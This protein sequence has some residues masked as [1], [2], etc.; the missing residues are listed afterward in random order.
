MDATLFLAPSV[1]SL[2]KFSR[3]SAVQQRLPVQQRRRTSAHKNNTL[4]TEK[5]SFKHRKDKGIHQRTRCVESP[6]RH[7]SFF[8]VHQ[9][10]FHAQNAPSMSI[11]IHQN[12]LLSTNF[13]VSFAVK[14]DLEKAV[15]KGVFRALTELKS[16]H[17][18]PS[19]VLQPYL[20]LVRSL[21]ILR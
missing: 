16:A 2:R 8:Y 15:Y 1:T 9:R 7:S 14:E 21:L 6:L 5:S 3:F 10:P 19:V 11:E 20:D 17:S 18:S 12:P 4:R 13:A